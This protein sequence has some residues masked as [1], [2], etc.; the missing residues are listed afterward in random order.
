MATAHFT[1]TG[2]SP[3]YFGAPLKSV[4]ASNEKENDFDK[5]VWLERAHIK[6]NGFLFQPAFGIK[7]MI[8]SAAAH[9]GEK[10]KNKG[11]KGILATGIAII[12]D[13][14]FDQKSDRLIMQPEFVSSGGQKGGGSRVW[15]HFPVLPTPWKLSGSIIVIDGRIDYDMLLRHLEEAGLFAGIG[16][17]RIDRGGQNGRFTAEITSWERGPKDPPAPAPAPAPDKPATTHKG[18]A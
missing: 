16:M 2:Q 12:D 6:P 17:W 10:L 4:R 3:V 1:L 14:L 9:K 18:K 8:E 13:P 7:R 5:R 15:R 11:V